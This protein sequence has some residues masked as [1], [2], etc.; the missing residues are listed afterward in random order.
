MCA[1][2]IN[3]GMIFT[4]DK[5]KEYR[6][7]QEGLNIW[8][9]SFDAWLAEKAAECGAEIRDGTFITDILETGDSVTVTFRGETCYM[10]TARY[11]VDCEGATGAL[12]RKLT[13]VK[14]PCIVTYQTYNRGKIDLD[15]EYFYAYLQPEFSEYDAWM[16]VKDGMLVMGVSVKNGSNMQAY[17]E[18][19]LSYM[20]Q[21][22]GLKIDEVLGGDKWLMPHARPGCP[23][24]YHVGRVFFAGEAAGFLCPMGEGISA[25]LES[26]YHAA[27]AIKEHFYDFDNAFSVYKTRTAALHQYM[28]RQWRLVA[29]LSASFAEM[30]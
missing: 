8:R 18:R 24:D 29:G 3:R 6:F 30:G 26:G 5:G 28:K 15:P 20:T 14:T 16:N 19:F 22:H 17:H 7:E 25:G 4:D 27:C 13:G 12:K 2:S 21:K 1:P 9:S 11:V 10:E 23:I